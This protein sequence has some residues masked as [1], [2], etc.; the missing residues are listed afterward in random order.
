[1]GARARP[2]GLVQMKSWLVAV[3]R[4]KVVSRP[5]L[6]RAVQGGQGRGVPTQM[7]SKESTVGEFVVDDDTYP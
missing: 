3:S 2:A 5:G 4:K 6:S 7:S 1:M